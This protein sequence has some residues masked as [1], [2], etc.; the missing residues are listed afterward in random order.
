MAEERLLESS[1][2]TTCIATRA[3]SSTSESKYTHSK[4]GW[5]VIQTFLNL[6]LQFSNSSIVIKCWRDTVLHAATQWITDFHASDVIKMGPS[7]YLGFVG[8]AAKLLLNVTSYKGV[9]TY[10]LILW[11]VSIILTQ[12]RKW[13]SEELFGY[14]MIYCLIMPQSDNFLH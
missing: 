12:N 8:Y 11:A 1:K 4:L 2:C 3:I 5:S 10:E 13:L 9:V 14:L 7:C 6:C